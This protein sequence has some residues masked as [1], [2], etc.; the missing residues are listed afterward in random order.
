MIA[1]LRDGARGDGGGE[2]AALRRGRMP[3][4]GRKG[5][6]SLMHGRFGGSEITRWLIYGTR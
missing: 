4:T 5:A 2:M 6:T 3:I 1:R